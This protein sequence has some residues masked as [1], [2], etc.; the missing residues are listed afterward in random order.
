MAQPSKSYALLATFKTVERRGWQ[1]HF[2]GE[3]RER[4]AAALAAQERPE[5]LFQAV[6]HGGTVPERL[7]HLWNV[8]FTLVPSCDNLV[9][10]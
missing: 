2:L 1:P 5:L 9:Q 7:F 10:D 8:S 4:Q 3:F 6:A